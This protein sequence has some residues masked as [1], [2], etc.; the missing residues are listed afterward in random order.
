MLKKILILSAGC[1]IIGTGVGW[2]QTQGK[3]SPAES[4]ESVAPLNRIA[5]IVNDEIISESDLDAA[6][7]QLKQQLAASNVAQPSP[8]TLRHDAL[9]QLINYRLQLQMASRNGITP[10][11][12]EVD[13]AILQIAQS[14]NLTLD[15]LKEQMALQQTPYNEFRK[16]IT[17]QLIITKLQQQMVAGQVKVSEQDVADFKKSTPGTQEYQLIDF[18]LPVSEDPTPAEWD[19]ALTT[20]HE[21]QKQIEEGVDIHKIT[22]PYQDLG[23]RTEDALP[24]IFAEQLS[25][26]SSQKTSPPLRAPNGYHLLALLATRNADQTLTDN[27]IRQIILRQKYEAAVKAAVDKARKEAYVQIIPE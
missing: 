2:A 1:L 3:V 22:P 17:N 5:A 18:F 9:E 6:I 25:S 20:E 14:H 7:D 13:E 26:L 16:K 10:T 8:S 12:K 15:Q 24:Q 21:I 4:T 23:W 19:R 11:P 27:K